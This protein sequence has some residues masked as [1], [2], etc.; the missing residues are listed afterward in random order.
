MKKKIVQEINQVLKTAQSASE[1]T[2]RVFGPGGF[3]SQLAPTQTERKK[4]LNSPLFAR[5]QARL[6]LMHAAE[7]EKFAREAGEN[8]GIAS[9]QMRIPRKSE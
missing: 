2:E 5:I 3:C 7:E 6:D 4:F 9:I 1:L 8:I